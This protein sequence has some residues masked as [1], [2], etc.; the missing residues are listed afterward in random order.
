MA[1]RLG[2]LLAS[3]TSPGALRLAQAH[4]GALDHVADRNA[5]ILSLDPDDHWLGKL[6][7]GLGQQTADCRRLEAGEVKRSPP[8]AEGVDGLSG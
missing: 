2:G 7:S 4:R 1:A 8:I 6:Q 5:I 3:T